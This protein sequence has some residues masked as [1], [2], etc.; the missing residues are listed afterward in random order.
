VPPPKDNDW[1]DGSGEEGAGTESGQLGLEQGSSS[2]R[3]GYEDDRAG[4]DGAGAEASEHEGRG[5]MRVGRRVRTPTRVNQR[6]GRED[7]GSGEEGVGGDASE[8]E[9]GERVRRA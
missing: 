1:V 8:Q 7:H 5:T 9:H 3:E 2:E 6:E 4:E